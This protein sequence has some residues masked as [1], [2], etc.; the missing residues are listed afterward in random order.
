MP[1]T[2]EDQI[3]EPTVH[4]C[5]SEHAIRRAAEVL[6]AANLNTMANDIAAHLP[7][8]IVEPTENFSVIMARPAFGTTVRP[9]TLLRGFWLDLDGN[10]CGAWDTL[11]DIEIL[12]NGLDVPLP[13]N[14]QLTE[15]FAGHHQTNASE[16]CGCG[17]VPNPTHRRSQHLAGVVL[18]LWDRDIDMESST[19]K[20][21]HGS[22][23]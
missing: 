17:H 13:S 18:A 8:P 22:R 9:L 2:D 19:T 5:W 15:L 3:T 6:Q 12:R 20:A 10:D 14:E 1:A 16:W 21:R 23:G 4:L 7:P 11:R